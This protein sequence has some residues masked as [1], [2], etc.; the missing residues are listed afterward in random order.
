[1]TDNNDS[2]APL[3]EIVDRT[4]AEQLLGCRCGARVYFRHGD[5]SKGVASIC[6]RHRTYNFPAYSIRDGRRVHGVLLGNADRRI[7]L[8]LA[9]EDELLT[10]SELAEAIDYWER[11]RDAQIFCLH[12]KSSGAVVFTD[13]GGERRFLLIKM[14][15]GHFGLPK[16]HIEKFEDERAAAIREIREETGV[17]ASLLDGFRETVRYTVSRKTHKESVYFIG[18]FDGGNVTIQRSEVSAYRLCPADEASGL[19][20]HDNDRAVFQ[21]AVRWLDE[22]YPLRPDTAI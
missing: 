1:M 16:G 20:T 19:I 10:Q 17:Q 22:H 9:P 2:A 13:N 8:I 18:C 5:V 12:E 4:T 6:S 7:S 11:G 21:N 15:R 14:N 3:A